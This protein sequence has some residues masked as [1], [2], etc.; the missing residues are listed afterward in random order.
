[1]TTLEDFNRRLS[2]TKDVLV[3]F[4]KSQLNLVSL[5]REKLRICAS[6]LI[7][8]LAEVDSDDAMRPEWFADVAPSAEDYLVDLMQSCMSANDP[9]PKAQKPATVYGGGMVLKPW[10]RFWR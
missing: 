9:A 8:F 2:T 3:G 1:M 6:S 5:D 4:Q 10:W 7:S